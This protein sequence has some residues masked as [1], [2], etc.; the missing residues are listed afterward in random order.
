M[1][2]QCV[3]LTSSPKHVNSQC[4]EMTFWLRYILPLLCYYKISYTR[5][6]LTYLL[7]ATLISWARHLAPMVTRLLYMCTCITK[8]WWSLISFLPHTHR[9]MLKPRVKPPFTVPQWLATYQCSKPYWSS[10]LTWRLRY[11]QKLKFKCFVERVGH[12]QPKLRVSLTPPQTLLSQQYSSFYSQ[13]SSLNWS[14]LAAHLHIVL[15]PD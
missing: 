6:P 10:N 3:K 12:S 9:L 7:H 1:Q 15:D 8:S 4:F 2:N 13:Q 5:P 11:L 14:R